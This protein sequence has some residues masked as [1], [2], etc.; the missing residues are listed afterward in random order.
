MKPNRH[1][2]REEREDAISRLAGGL[3]RREP[4]AD[5][6][7]KVEK[8]LA[9]EFEIAA[10]RQPKTRGVRLGAGR[11]LRAFRLADGGWSGMRISAAA[12][13]LVLLSV[14]SVPALRRPAISLATGTSSG[15]PAGIDREAARAEREYRRAIERLTVLA[16]KNEKAIE[17]GLLALYREKLDL[18]DGSIRECRRALESNYRNPAA[19]AALLYCYRQKAETLK[20]MAEA[21][22][23]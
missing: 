3:D 9:A 4:P 18:L 2:V 22:P 7:P 16:G 12:L 14:L 1:P 5:L 19:H 15:G 6:W 8:R 10:S 11:W 23:S 21:K 13:A 17:P 20:M